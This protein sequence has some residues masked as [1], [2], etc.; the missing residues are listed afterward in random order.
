MPPPK[1]R[2][3]W[4]LGTGVLAGF[5]TVLPLRES[6]AVRDF[7]ASELDDALSGWEHRAIMF[8]AKRPK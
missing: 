2:L 7:F 8:I 4:L 5:D 6:G 1:D 3:D